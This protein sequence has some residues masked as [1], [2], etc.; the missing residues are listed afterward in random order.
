MCFFFV[1][2]SDFYFLSDLFYSNCY[3]ALG[4]DTSGPLKDSGL[5][6]QRLKWVQAWKLLGCQLEVLE[7]PQH[8]LHGVPRLASWGGSWGTLESFLVGRRGLL[9]ASWGLLGTP[10]QLMGACMA[11]VGPGFTNLLF[12]PGEACDTIIFVEA[13]LAQPLFLSSGRSR[14]H[15]FCQVGI[16]KTTIFFQ[17]ALAKPIFL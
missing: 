9:G 15:Y 12:C 7:V 8:S 6:T 5:D 4:L 1:F 17:P 3:M 2:R 16:C 13:G 14:N 10:L 11:S